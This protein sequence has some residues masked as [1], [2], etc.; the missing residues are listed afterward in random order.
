MS[1]KF[2]MTDGGL[3]I[4]MCLNYKNNILFICNTLSDNTKY[5]SN[6]S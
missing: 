4:N 5:L 6:K 3:N 1:G 2:Q